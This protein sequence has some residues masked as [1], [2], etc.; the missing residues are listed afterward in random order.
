MSS[1]NT[2]NL[3]LN[4]A[5]PNTQ[6]PFDP[7]VVNLNWDKIDAAV[8]AKSSKFTTTTVSN[9]TT[10]TLLFS[11]PI[12][13]PVQGAVYTM[14]IGGTVDHASGATATFRGKLAGTAFG[15][16]GVSYPASVLTNQ[17]WRVQLEI[18]IL[19]LGALG[20]WKGALNGT[21]RVNGANVPMLE[22][23]SGSLTRTT[24]VTSNLEL[25]VQWTAASASSIVRADYGY[26]YRV[27]NA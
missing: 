17:P 21:A 9:T 20:T 11:M 23:P 10:E 8:G 19:T 18:T 26:A 7:A 2:P 27:T 4:K 5:T 22:V 6:E 24:L 14:V 12:D 3:G 13:T 16:S 15:A 25:T 1:T